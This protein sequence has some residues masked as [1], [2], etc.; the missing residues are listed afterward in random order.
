MSA[1]VVIIIITCL[2][3]Y[4]AFN[5]SEFFYKLAHWPMREHGAREHYRLVTSGFVHGGWIHLLINMFVFY[6]FGELIEYHF[7]Q[8]FGPVRGLVYYVLVYLLTIACASLPSYFKRKQDSQYIAVGASGGVSGI[9]FIF[10][11]LYP[12]QTLLLYGI[13]PIPAIIGGI[14]YLWYSSYASKNKQD[15]IDHEAHFYGAIFG[16]VFTL[17][18]KPSLALSFAQRLVENFPL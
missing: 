1:T 6:S 17:L 11:L 8:F 10:I 7:A 9:V 4:N 14:A 15:R 2:V 16:I 18:L 5:N 13:I 12:W 3:S